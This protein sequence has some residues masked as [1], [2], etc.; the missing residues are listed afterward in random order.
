MLGNI[1]HVSPNSSLVKAL[2]LME[3][4]NTSYI[5]LMDNNDYRGI[6]TRMVVAKRMLQCVREKRGLS[7]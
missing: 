4:H 3:L 5:F 1:P 7:S 6:V 2:A